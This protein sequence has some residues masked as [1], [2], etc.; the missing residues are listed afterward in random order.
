LPIWSPQ[1]GR[2]WM[3]V[4][5]VSILS[6]TTSFASLATSSSSFILISSVVQ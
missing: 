1:I 4:P 6:A 3:V 5:I 2:P